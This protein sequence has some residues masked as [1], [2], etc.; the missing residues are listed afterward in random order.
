MSPGLAVVHEL[1]TTMQHPVSTA[2]YQFFYTLFTLPRTWH[3]IRQHE[4]WRGLEQYGWVVRMLVVVAILMGLKFI[5]LFFEWMGQLES[6]D[7]SGIAMGMGGLFTAGF[8]EGYE[9]FTAGFMRYVMLIL[10]EVVVFHFMRRSLAILVARESG[11]G[12]QDFISAQIRMIK[13][14]FRSWVLELVT[15]ILIGVV[16]GFFSILEFFEPALIFGVQC[17]YLGFAIV[18]NY[19]EQFGLSIKQSVAYARG[20]IG[21]SLALGLVLYLLMLIP[22]VGTVAGPLLVSV[23]GALVLVQLSDLHLEA[24]TA[25]V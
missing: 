14:V 25:E 15:T 24:Y 23:A 19:N 4:L 9:M 7:L 16:C 5:S 13:V 10:L 3:F 20:Y 12:L 17:F 11:V 1:L 2:I 22:L 8:L 6:F 21:V 18:D